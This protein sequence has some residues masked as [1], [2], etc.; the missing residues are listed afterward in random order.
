MRCFTAEFGMESGGSSA[1]WSSSKTVDAVGVVAAVG[2][3]TAPVNL[4]TRLAVDGRR[5]TV[6]GLRPTVLGYAYLETRLIA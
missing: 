2:G 1:L 5:F 6:Y 3:W 4:L